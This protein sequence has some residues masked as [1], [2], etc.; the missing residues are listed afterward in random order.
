MKILALTKSFPPEIGTASHLFFELCE[1][2]V[3][4]GHEVTVIT[5]I[6]W[7]N[8]DEIESH[9]RN[10]LVLEEC[11]NGIKVVR[12]ANIPLPSG[13]RLQAGHVLVPPI[14]FLGGLKA[15]K[16]E[17]II[18]Y[19]PPLLMG[20]TAYCFSRKWQ[21]PF[22]FNAQDLYPQCLVDLGQ[23][24]NRTLIRLLE[25]IEAFIYRKAALITVHSQGNKDFLTAHKV[26][27][28][29]NVR[30]M[31]NWVDT[32]LIQPGERINDFAR[33]HNLEKKFVVSFA[34]TMGISQGIVSVVEAAAFLKEYPDILVLLVGGGLDKEQARRKAQE[35]G[36]KNVKF[37]PMQTREIYPQVLAASDVCLVPLKKD[38]RTPVLPSKILGIMA[39]GRPVLASMPLEGDAPKLIREAQCGLC[40]E[41]GNPKA[42]AEA[43]LTLRRNPELCELYGHNG[44]RYAEQHFSRESCVAK[45][46]ALF[47]EAI[48]RYRSN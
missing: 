10:R 4:H 38:I 34:G 48:S 12:V 44:R 17:V 41:P 35:L 37:L 21:V 20:L 32:Q 46:E 31:A 42:L 9:Y 14:F 25:K 5:S 11:L 1:T 28:A 39:A 3:E 36:I 45:Y 22:I 23:L 47:Q 26:V 6:P 8:L 7:Y 16:P 13:V 33:Q 2:L 24:R 27:A 18:V 19:S 29:A 40:V 43:I 15:P 30:V